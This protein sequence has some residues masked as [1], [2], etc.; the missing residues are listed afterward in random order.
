MSLRAAGAEQPQDNNAAMQP[1]VIQ[2]HISTGPS[3][4][5]A[6]SGIQAKDGSLRDSITSSGEDLLDPAAPSL[7]PGQSHTTVPASLEPAAK[8]ITPPH[9]GPYCCPFPAPTPI[10][11]T[12]GSAVVETLGPDS[13]AW[14]GDREMQEYNDNASYTGLTF[15]DDP[16]DK[17]SNNVTSL[18][19][20]NQDLGV[21]GLE[22]T[23]NDNAAKLVDN[24]ARI[25]QLHQECMPQRSKYNN[26]AEF[27]KAMEAYYAM[28]VELSNVM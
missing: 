6:A 11:A 19:A 28:D 23:D 25:R 9:G 2:Q 3:K 10:N 17:D 27:D 5:P 7:P 20:F 24:A 15:K 21:D 18:E 13:R 16:D 4:G 1:G 22:N 12:P 14:K 8:S 26:K